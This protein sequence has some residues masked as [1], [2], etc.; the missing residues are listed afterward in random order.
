MTAE[1]RK[2]TKEAY[3]KLLKKI[4]G[5]EVAFD[6]DKDLSNNLYDLQL[7][8]TKVEPEARV[9]SRKY[10][11]FQ[12][13]YNSEISL[14]AYMEAKL[15][16]QDGE[17]VKFEERVSRRLN[18]YD[19]NDVVACLL[20][21]GMNLEDIYV[22]KDSRANLKLTPSI[23]ASLMSEFTLKGSPL[24]AGQELNYAGTKK[25]SQ[26][27]RDFYMNQERFGKK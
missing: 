25:F 21:L 24:Y 14:N 1:E 5:W 6:L 8:L 2:K 3:I 27:R 13:T 7:F 16:A 22:A 9:C 12:V 11:F 17:L 18:P 26:P 19:I 4:A 23:I 10:N 15:H 20:H